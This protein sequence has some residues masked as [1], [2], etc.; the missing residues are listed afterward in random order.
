MKI[1]SESS[2]EKCRLMIEKIARK[3]N[4]ELMASGMGFPLSIHEFQA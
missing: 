3:L 2:Y 4:G 1:L